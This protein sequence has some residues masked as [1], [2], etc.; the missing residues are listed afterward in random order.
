M[1]LLTTILCGAGG[2]E[3]ARLELSEAAV[4]VLMST[5]TV[6]DSTQ[7]MPLPQAGLITR[8]MLPEQPR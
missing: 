6:W 5:R 4:N 8:A 3:V 2:G 7:E 1:L